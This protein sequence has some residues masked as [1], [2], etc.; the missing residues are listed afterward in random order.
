MTFPASERVI[1]EKNPLAQVICQLRFP[2]ILRISTELPAAF[3]ERVRSQFPMLR[4]RDQSQLASLVQ[5]VGLPQQLLSAIPRLGQAAVYDFDTRQPGWRLTL[6]Q[7]ALALTATNYQR[8]EDFKAHLLEGHTALKEVYDPNFYVRVG[9]RYL[10][11]IRRSEIGLDP[12]TPWED[13][14]QPHVLGALATELAPQ[15]RQSVHEVLFNVD[16]RISV[17]LRH[18]L[19]VVDNEE[20]YEIDADF[21]SDS[22]TETDDA[23]KTLD[24]LNHESGRLF[25]WCIRTKLHDAMAPVGASDCG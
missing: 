18:G 3:Q 11:V 4:T 23:E 25:R 1:Y 12:S 6:S 13:L 8:W 22:Q 7:E 14:L 15:V 19:L 5:Q 16:E 9:L 2:P 24:A 21:F 20:A 10:N 17:R